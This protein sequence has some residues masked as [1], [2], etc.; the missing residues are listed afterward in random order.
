MI[1]EIHERAGLPVPS[2]SSSFWHSEPSP[3]L[4]SHR[5]TADLPSFADVVIIGSGITGASA[6][7]YL[8]EDPK[9]SK[10]SVVMLE[11][12]EAVSGA[13]G[14]NGGHCQPLLI[15]RTPDIAAFEVKNVAAVR[16]YIE[17][18]NVP[19]EWRTVTA[20]MAL[21]DSKNFKAAEQVREVGRFK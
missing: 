16:S 1:K 3:F 15:R 13:T 17:Q 9:A 10:L 12:R 2:S 5:T 20:C 8:A 21:L 6:A 7:R 4:L 11:A 19:C 14:R 18:H